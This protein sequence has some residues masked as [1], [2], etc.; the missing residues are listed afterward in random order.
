MSVGY[1]WIWFIPISETRVSVGL[2]THA[3]YYK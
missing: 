2:V 3:E 1:G